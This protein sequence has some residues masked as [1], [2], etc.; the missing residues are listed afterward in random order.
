MTEAE[1][2]ELERL[3]AVNA[4]LVAVLR[5]MTKKV[6]AMVDE[7]GGCD[8]AADVCCCE[9][10]MDLEEARAAIASAGGGT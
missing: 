8:H 2:S 6:Q 5:T 4:E 9:D 1:Q 10:I 3:R 7:I